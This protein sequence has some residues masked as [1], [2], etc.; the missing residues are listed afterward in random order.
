M[1]SYFIEPNIYFVR[2]E[3]KLSLDGLEL[4]YQRVDE[5][6]KYFPRMHYVADMSKCNR[7]GP[8][9]RTLFQKNAAEYDAIYLQKHFVVPKVLRTV[10]R[11][12]VRFVP[13]YQNSLRSI[14]DPYH[15]ILELIVNQGD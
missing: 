4:M 2:F 5:C 6:R 15:A 12:F 10:Y 13:S 8:G 14:S 9:V 3:G 11:L 7:L 1:I